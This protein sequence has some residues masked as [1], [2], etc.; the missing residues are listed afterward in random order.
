MRTKEL[1][2]QI[3]R[4]I[5][6]AIEAGAGEYRMPWHRWGE[7]LSSPTNFATRKPYRGINIL[8]LWAAAEARGYSS[9]QW[10]TYRQW[11]AMGAQVRKGERATTI[12]L[13]KRN[14][15]SG[16]QE[17]EG[18]EQS[19]VPRVLARAYSVFNVDQVDGAA[20]IRER[21][22][23]ADR[24]VEADEFFTAIGATVRHG[25]DKACYVPA[26]DEI[27]MPRFEQFSESGSYY[28]VFA[29]EH[30]HWT[31][32][33]KRLNRNLSDRFGTD[34]YAIEE[35]IAE[36][37][38]AFLAGHLELSVEPRPDHAAYIQAWLR[39]LRGDPRAIITAS[40]KAQ[41]AAD[42]LVDLVEQRRPASGFRSAA[43]EQMAA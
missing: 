37:G 32:A 39:V 8:I 41:Q 18:E 12:V 14:V 4:N 5:T 2:E 28:S 31:G 20:V 43:A 35:L 13:W 17:Q 15:G 25:G 10:A 27:W 6:A 29:H 23:L 36:L 42:Y 30:V 1:F 21:P 16:S 33:A 7:S 22:L 40:A 34:A 11:A 26:A 3:T 19:Y 38:A 24:L 9:G